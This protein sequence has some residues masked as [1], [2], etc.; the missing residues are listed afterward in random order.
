M[1]AATISAAGFMLSPTMQATVTAVSGV[2]AAQG[3]APEQVFRLDDEWE[4]HSGS[5]SGVEEAWL[6][7]QQSEWEAVTMPHCFN[8]LDACDPDK[9]YFRGHG[10]Y[11]RRVL[12]RNPHANGRTI[13]HF[14]GQAKPLRCGL[15]R[16]ALGHTSADTTSSRSILPKP[17]RNSRLLSEPQACR[18]LC[19]VTTLPMPTGFLRS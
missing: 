10:W 15:D 8:A 14:Q 1:Q 11:R 5:I 13:L 17:S 18:R 2:E 6:P 3:V 7:T 16:R 12:V 4:F 9:S 19:S